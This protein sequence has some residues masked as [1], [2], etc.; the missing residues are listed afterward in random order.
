MPAHFFRKSMAVLGL[1]AL[2]GMAQAYPDRPLTLVVPFPPTGTPDIN[3]TP[4]ITKM[5][6]LVQSLSTPALTD[7]L[8]QSLASGLA[9]ALS[10]PVLI[11]RKASGMTVEGVQYVARS[12]TDGHTLLFAGSPTLTIYPALFRALALDSRRDLAPVAPLAEL[13]I[14]L[15]TDADNPARSV[16]AVIERL[17]FVPGQVNF[18]GLGEGTSSQLAHEAF[19]RLTGTQFVRVSYNGSTPALNAVATRNVEF[20][21]VPLTAALPFVGGGKIRLVAVGSPRRHPAA[22][23]VPTLAESGVD[24]YAAGGWFGVFARAGTAPAVVSLLN[25]NINRVTAEDGW[26]R[27]LV[28]RGLF[29]ARATPEE[30]R[31]RIDADAARAAQWLGLV[32]VP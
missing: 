11:E 26:Q 9:A 27:M 25:Y 24:G 22:P 8:A 19:R 31:A 6:K 21:F 17:R 32:A 23:D 5:V 13:P 12:A 20:G 29:A 16:R 18:A 7:A 10:Q 3:G 14:A 2:C 30:F 1:A 15:V 28:E 4:R